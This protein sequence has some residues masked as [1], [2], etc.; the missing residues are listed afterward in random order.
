MWESSLPDSATG[1]GGVRSGGCII[2]L[3][4][5]GMT[6]AAIIDPDYLQRTLCLD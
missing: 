3:A 2:R 4:E 1:K 5:H 6:F